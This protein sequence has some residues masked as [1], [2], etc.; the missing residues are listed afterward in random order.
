MDVG[1][2]EAADA[3]DDD[4][5]AREERLGLSRADFF[6]AF[7]SDEIFIAP[8]SSCIAFSLATVG[9]IDTGAVVRASILKEEYTPSTGFWLGLETAAATEECRDIVLFTELD[10]VTIA[11]KDD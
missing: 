1:S 11:D 4:A 7:A 2:I 6:D 9:D 8:V 10:F 5:I 3:R